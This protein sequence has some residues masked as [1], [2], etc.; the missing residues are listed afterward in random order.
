[1]YNFAYTSFQNTFGGNFLYLWLHQ[2]LL[3]YSFIALSQIFAIL[4]GQFG[5][6]FNI[7]TAKQLVSSG[8]I[9][10]REL[11]LPFIKV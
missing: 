7:L 8:E 11:L 4:L 10:S 5:M 9:A 2:V 1:M 6:M 3:M